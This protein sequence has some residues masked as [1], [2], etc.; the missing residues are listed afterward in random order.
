M[1][2]V[3]F[4]QAD[5]TQQELDV[6]PGVSLMEAARENL[7]AGIVAECGGGAICGTCHVIVDTAW[8][9]K[10]EAP[11]PSELALVEFVPES[12]PCSRLACQIIMDDSLDGIEVAMPCEQ[13]QM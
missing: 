7:I 8:M 13:L 10:L 12:G 9:D 2:R 3:V 6:A 1:A 4:K 5:G 11:S